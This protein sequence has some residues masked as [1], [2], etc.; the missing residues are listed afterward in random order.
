MLGEVDPRQCHHKDDT[1]ET[2]AGQRNAATRNAT[3]ATWPL[4]NEK[5]VGDSRKGRSGTLRTSSA[6][7]G[8]CGMGSLSTTSTATTIRSSSGTHQ[9][10]PAA[11]N[12]KIATPSATA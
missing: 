12:R 11:R 7:G 2:P 6:G 1:I 9:S 8:L 4:G 10:R 5:V 3:R